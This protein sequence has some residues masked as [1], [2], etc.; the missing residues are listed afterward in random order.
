MIER[1]GRVRLAQQPPAGL[2]I[3]GAL[4]RDELDR[5][6]SIE[7]RVAREVHLAHAASPQQSTQLVM[8][9]RVLRRRN[10]RHVVPAALRR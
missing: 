9:E 1:R 3:G 10:P 2:L 6:V 8:T 7:R 5:D 4:G